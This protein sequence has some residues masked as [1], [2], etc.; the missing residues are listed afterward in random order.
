M[1]SYFDANLPQS[2][3]PKSSRWTPHLKTIHCRPAAGT[4]GYKVTR[5]GNR[6]GRSPPL[7]NE[8][9]NMIIKSISPW[10]SL[11]NQIL[12][13]SIH[14]SHVHYFGVQKGL[15]MGFHGYINPPLS[16]TSPPSSFVNPSNFF[17]SPQKDGIVCKNLH[18]IVINDFS[19]FLGAMDIVAYPPE[20]QFATQMVVLVYLPTFRDT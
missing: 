10:Y 11:F 20:T 17:G 6:Q 3:L 18:K 8:I 13:H 9:G 15:F 16:G 19:I 2:H 12:S 5:L 4:N 14:I 1:R 7:L